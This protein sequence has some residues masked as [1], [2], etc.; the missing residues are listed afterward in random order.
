MFNVI[1]M[2]KKKPESIHNEEIA[3]SDNYVLI[4]TVYGVAS[5]NS[6]SIDLGLH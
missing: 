3:W 5:S 1:C 4:K 6:K 2:L